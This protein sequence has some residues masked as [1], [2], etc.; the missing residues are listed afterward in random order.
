MSIKQIIRFNRIFFVANLAV[1]VG[2]AALFVFGATDLFQPSGT[3]EVNRIV[4]RGT[5]G[6]PTMV[7]QGDDENTLMTLN[8]SQG[9]V[10]LQL[11]TPI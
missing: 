10:R 1:F 7:L 5:S 8:D 3:L 4:L 11:S 9:N 2:I 6:V